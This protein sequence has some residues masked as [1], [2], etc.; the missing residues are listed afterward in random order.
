[1]HDINRDERGKRVTVLGDKIAALLLVVVG[2]V[3]VL[4]GVVALSPRRA[5]AVYGITLDDPDLVLLLRHRAIVLAL[6][7]VGLIIG[8]FTPPVRPVVVGAAL[9]SL[10]SFIGLTVRARPGGVNAETRRVAWIDVGAVGL[11]VIASCLL[12][13]AN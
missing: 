7:G 1:M 4:P 9:I 10:V 3:H 13:V 6:I 2:V 8:A 12:V 5:P 11:L